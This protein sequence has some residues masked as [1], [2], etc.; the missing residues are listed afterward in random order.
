MDWVKIF[1]GISSLSED[2]SLKIISDAFS[3]SENV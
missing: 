3:Y 2:L 1:E